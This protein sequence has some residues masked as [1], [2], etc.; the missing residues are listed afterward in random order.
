MNH[1]ENTSSPNEQAILEASVEHCFQCADAFFGHTFLRASCNLKQRGK[2]AGT[3]HLQ[4]NEVRFNAFMYRQSPEKFLSTVVPHEVAHIIVYQ[5]YGSNVRPHGKEW[6]AVMRKVFGLS[7]DR[8]HD[9]DVPPPKTQFLYAC[10]CQQHE[11]TAR[12]HNKVMRGTEYRC[13]TC[14]QKLSFVN[15][16]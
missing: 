13:K 12:R 8:T 2:A 4:K 9:F 7:P 3:A 5:I 15:Q 14:L 1:E 11:F 16:I 10:Q 6:Q